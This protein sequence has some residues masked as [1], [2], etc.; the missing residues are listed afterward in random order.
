MNDE[1]H[2]TKG[3]FF[4]WMMNGLEAEVISLPFTLSSGTT[5]Y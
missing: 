2:F 3:D 5:V 4:D 1:Y